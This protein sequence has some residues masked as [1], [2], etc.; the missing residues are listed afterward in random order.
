MQQYYFTELLPPVSLFYQKCT[1]LQFYFALL[2]LVVNCFSPFIETLV[3]N[4]RDGRRILPVAKN[5]LIFL[6]R[7]ILL[8]KFT[9]KSI[10]SIIEKCHIESIILSPIKKSFFLCNHSIQASFVPE[11][12]DTA[13]FF[14]TSGFQ[15]T[16]V[17]PILI[18]RC[19][20]N[21]IFIVTKMFNDQN[22]SL[23]QHFYFHFPETYAQKVILWC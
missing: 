16:Y 17:M 5:L 10:K 3:G 11:V 22:P 6:I 14:L 21:V 2:L 1:L 15:Y 19:L 7:K 12:I 4:P 18:N 13:S 23:K 9:S 8:T 20:L